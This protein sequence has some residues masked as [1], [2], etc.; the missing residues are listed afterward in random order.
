M[1]STSARLFSLRHMFLL[2]LYVFSAFC[3]ISLSAQ[4]STYI[5]AATDRWASFIHIFQCLELLLDAIIIFAVSEISKDVQDPSEKWKFVS[6]LAFTS[7]AVLGFLCCIFLLKNPEHISW[8]IRLDSKVLTDLFVSGLFCANFIGSA[9]YLMNEVRLTLIFTITSCVSIY[10]Y[11]LSALYHRITSSSTSFHG[12]SQGISVV[13]YASV[14][15]LFQMENYESRSQQN[16]F[17]KKFASRAL[18]ALCFF[19][20]ITTTIF[21]SKEAFSSSQSRWV[22]HPMDLLISNARS[23]ADR[24]LEQAMSS[25]SLQEAIT[26]YQ[27]RYM[28]PPPPQFDKWYDFAISRGSLIVDDFCQIHRDLLP[29]W[30][31]EPLRIRQMT[32]HMLERPW[33][34]V[35]GLRISNGTAHVGP[36]V[37]GTHR[38]MLEGAAEMINTF[39]EWLPDMDIAFNLNDECRVAIPWEEMQGLKLGAELARGQLNR[40]RNIRSFGA[41]TSQSWQGNIMEPEPLYPADVP[42]EYFYQ[43]SV[44]SS[45]EQYGV[46]ACLPDSPARKYTWWNKKLSCQGCASP[47]SLGPFLANWELSGSL[48]HQPDIKTL[49]GFHLSPSAFK[50]TKSLFPIFSQSKIPTFSDIIFPSPWNYKDKVFYD[51]SQDMSFSEKEDTIFWRGATSEGFSTGGTWQGMQRQRFVHLVNADPG[52]STVNLILPKKG[53]DVN[54]IEQRIPLSDISSVTNISVAFVG[55]TVRCYDYDCELQNRELRFSSPIPFED[56]WRFKYLF[57]LDGAGFSGRFLPFLQSRSLVFRAAAFRTWFD[58]RLTAWIHFVPVDGRLHDVWDLLAYFG[59]T[60]TNLKGGHIAEAEIVAQAGRKH[61]AQVLRKEDME[62][63]MFRLLLEWGR[64]VD[65]Q[66]N[67]MGFN[68]TPTR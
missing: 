55:D 41:N 65:D 40:T 63:Y 13:A 57:D 36:R 51:A 28:I 42:S 49:H 31:I 8:A 37:I 10:I 12:L 4:R 23:K 3:I 53:T 15:G 48:C 46:I 2:A 52:S 56:H 17:S 29:F 39:A 19:M 68:S 58:E 25:R 35:A 7:A 45:F 11:H 54:Y 61:A 50:P 47:H 67:E 66:R 1:K 20:L 5:C 60:R 43:S 6:H 26:E 33:T 30:G 32:E 16:Q 64:I 24:W 21:G 38:W 27:S 18:T 9:A 62:V 34:E 14:V 44:A 59:G 22:V